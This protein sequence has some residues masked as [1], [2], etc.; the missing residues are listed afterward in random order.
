MASKRAYGEIPGH[1]PGSTFKNRDELADSG[2]HRPN[3]AGICG[4]KD[5]AESIM[6]SGGYVDDEEYGT[7]I[8]YTGQGGND[9]ATKRQIADQQLIRGD[10]GLARSQI[11]A[12]DPPHAFQVCPH[13][14]QIS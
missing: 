9:P 14:R 6:V 10:L 5:G 2:V 1:P 11:D 8:V 12:V 13:V 7:E 4:G 3:Q